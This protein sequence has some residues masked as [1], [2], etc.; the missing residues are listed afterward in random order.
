MKDVAW[1]VHNTL[2]NLYLTESES[3]AMV[4]VFLFLELQGTRQMGGGGPATK[5][6][7]GSARAQSGIAHS[8]IVTNKI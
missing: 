1:D 8:V 4:R 3:G 2:L 6:A 7:Q 5:I